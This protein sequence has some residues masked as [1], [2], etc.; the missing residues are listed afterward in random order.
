MEGRRWEDLS[1]DCLVF[2]FSKLGLEDLTLGVSLVCKSFHGASM[3]P[4]CWKFLDFQNLDFSPNSKFVAR[5]KHEYHVNAFSF[6]SLLKLCSRRSHGCA[7]KLSIPSI[8]AS[9]LLSDLLLASIQC[10]RLKELTLPT[11]LHQDDKQ[12]P[13]LIGK[14]K[15]LETLQLKWKPISFLEM[16]EEI[17]ANCPKFTELRL[18]GVIDSTDAKAIV[19]NFPGL[20][21]LAMTSSFLRRE[22]LV[23]ILDGC[24]EL[25]AVDVSRCRGFDGDDE[26]LK[27]FSARIK[28]FVSDGCKVG[29][30]YVNSY[31]SYGNLF[32]AMIFGDY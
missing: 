14:W 15:E 6:N 25:R 27:R 26:M 12:I 5:F 2:I 17:R 10:P 24:G 31:R 21:R 1:F 3:D 18:R 7:T 4:K 9:P 28:D 16:V 30:I 13:G 32:L 19:K 11:L 20:K 23:T 22:D 8:N 29:E